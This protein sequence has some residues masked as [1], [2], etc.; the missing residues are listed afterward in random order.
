MVTGLG[1]DEKD[2]TPD[3][4]TQTYGSVLC[5]FGT[6]ELSALRALRDYQ[7]QCRILNPQRDERISPM[8]P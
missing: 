5:T 8:H 6:D 4:W 1:V 7:K 3:K 2:V